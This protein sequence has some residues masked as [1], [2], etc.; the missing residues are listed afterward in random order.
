VSSNSPRN[1]AEMRLNTIS[2]VAKHLTAAYGGVQQ[3][4]LFRRIKHFALFFKFCS[5]LSYLRAT[6]RA[7]FERVLED[8]A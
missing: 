8:L 7:C 5:C 6:H 4:I 1:K 3:Y 2:H